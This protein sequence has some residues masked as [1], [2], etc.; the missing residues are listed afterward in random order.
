MS[1]RLYVGIDS[2]TQGTKAILLSENKR[3]VIAESYRGYG[4]L[5]NNRGGRE[6]HPETWINACREV[7]GEVLSNSAVN[8]KQ[9][10]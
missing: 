5:E 6:Q 3:S 2:G 8:S 1:D 9:V 4:L 7:L 10:K